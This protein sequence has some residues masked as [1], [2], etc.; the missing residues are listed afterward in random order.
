[1]KNQEFINPPLTQAI[2]DAILFGHIK[3]LDAILDIVEAD[4]DFPEELKYGLEAL[5]YFRAHYGKDAVLE[6]IER[7]QKQKTLVME[8]S[9]GS[10]LL[11][12]LHRSEA[13]AIRRRA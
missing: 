9:W 2:E 12:M 6:P 11:D 4:K 5:R 7:L 3:E 13:R 8:S 1:M 10:E